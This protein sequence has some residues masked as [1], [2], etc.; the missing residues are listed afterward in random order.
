M[1][2]FFHCGAIINL[3]LS[4]LV[5][6]LLRFFDEVVIRIFNQD[7]NLVQTASKAL[8]LFA[9][10]FIPMALNLIFTAFMFST[11]RTAQANTIAICRGIVIK[12]IA[13]FCI[14]ILFSSNAIWIA[15]FIAEIFTLI[16][17][18]ILTKTTKL[19]YK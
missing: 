9:L 13:V 19:V 4:I 1:K 14:P 7:I 16:I 5:Y 12:A 3:I 17:A 2:Y 18:I 11:K 8:P 6:T 10:S 15:Q